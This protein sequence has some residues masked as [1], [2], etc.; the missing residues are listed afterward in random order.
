MSSYEGLNVKENVTLAQYSTFRCGGPARLFAQPS[1]EEEIIALLNAAKEN[2]DEVF[3]LGSGSN[4]LFSDDGFDGL[5]IKIGREFGEVT[6]IDEGDTGLVIA[7]AGAPMATFGMKCAEHSLQ[8][9]EFI[10]GIPGSVGGGV[11]MNAGAYGGEI[12]NIAVSVRYIQ[13]GEVHEMSAEDAKFGYRTSIF[14][15]NSDMIITGF[16]ARLPKGDK[17]QIDELIAELRN[18][19]TKSQPLDVPSAGSTFK[20]P[21]GHFAGALIEGSGLKGFALNDSGA[22]VSPKHAG[23]VVNNGGK[24]KASDVMELIKYIQDK[25]FADSGVHLETEVRLVGGKK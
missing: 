17:A 8:G 6:V 10:C 21:E 18:K 20:R 15:Q 11:Y 4:I 25:V 1:S 12:K 2:N 14:E 9:A 7:Q 24:A 16:T 5:V 13:N 3:I 19:R 23:F 22:Q